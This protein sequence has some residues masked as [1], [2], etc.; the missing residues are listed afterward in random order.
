MTHTVSAFMTAWIYK[1]GEIMTKFLIMPEGCK[2]TEREALTPE[3]AYSLESSWY[4]PG[5]RIAVMNTE[6]GQT[7]V[8]TRE[9][10]KKG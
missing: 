1:G 10:D 7:Q 5:H 3:T 4:S 6:N 9:A 2:W 8:F